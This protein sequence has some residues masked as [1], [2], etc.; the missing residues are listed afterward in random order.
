MRPLVKGDCLARSARCLGGHGTPG[1][2]DGDPER[3]R[4]GLNSAGHRRV[5]SQTDKR[6]S[7]FYPVSSDPG[8][9]RGRFAALCLEGRGVVVTGGAPTSAR[10]TIMRLYWGAAVLAALCGACTGSV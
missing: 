5:A 1:Q 2:V 8:E 9:T 6:V 3:P 4:R 7:F 10:R